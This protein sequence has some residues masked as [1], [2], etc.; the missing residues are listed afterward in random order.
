MGQTLSDV[1]YVSGL[2]A[3]LAKDSACAE[4]LSAD[5]A[6]SRTRPLHSTSSVI[7]L[8]SPGEPQAATGQVECNVVPAHEGLTEVAI[9]NHIRHEH[10]AVDR[11]PGHGL[12]LKPLFLALR[13]GP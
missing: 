10:K 1:E 11:H 4:N 5:Q 8:P 13:I 3:P 6:R 2:I 9:H 7:G 12:E